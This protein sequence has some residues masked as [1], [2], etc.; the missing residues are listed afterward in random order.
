MNERRKPAGMRTGDWIEALIRE[1]EHEGKFDRVG[2]A[3]DPMAGV[4]PDAPDEEDWWLKKLI[5]RERLTVMPE[6]LALKRE[7]SDLRGALAL[8]PSEAALRT[9][10]TELNGRIA[11][12]NL[13]NT[14]PVASDLAELDVESLVVR[15]RAV[16]AEAGT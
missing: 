16:K 8:I 1:A 12:E 10:V 4:D 11:L 9:R 5:A 3:P 7:I 13:A 2:E 6:M 15:W 14:S